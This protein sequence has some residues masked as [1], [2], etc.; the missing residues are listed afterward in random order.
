M[1]TC[2]QAHGEEE[3]A[4]VRERA[5]ERGRG[6]REGAIAEEARNIKPFNPLT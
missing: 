5:R 2:E 6:R 1:F 4:R 3:E